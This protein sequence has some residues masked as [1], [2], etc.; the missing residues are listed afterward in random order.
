[1][2]FFDKKLEHWP[3][4][5]QIKCKKFERTMA[6]IRGGKVAYFFLGGAIFWGD[7]VVLISTDIYYLYFAGRDMIQRTRKLSL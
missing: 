1:V 4:E 6:G 3:I 5:I 7:T 2:F